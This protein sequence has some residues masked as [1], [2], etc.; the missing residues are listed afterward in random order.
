MKL[1]DRIKEFFYRFDLMDF[2]GKREEFYGQLAESMA[3]KERL[4]TFLVEELQI[5]SAPKTR[6]RSRAL[7]LGLMLKK[8]SSGKEFRLSQILGEVMPSGDRLMLTAL[9]TAKDKVA[10][11]HA[12]REGIAQQREAKAVIFKAI[13]PPLILLPGVGGFSWVMATRSLPVIVDIAPPQ[14]WTN[15]NMAVRLFSEF[16]ASNGLLTVAIVGAAV[17]ALGYAMPRWKGN[18]RGRFEQCS[19]Q[20][21]MLLFPVCPVLLPLSIYRDFQVANLMIS[22][23]VLL[24]SGSTLTDALVTLR[25]NSTPWMRWHLN[26]IL[27]HLQVAPIDYIPAFAKGLMSPKLLARLATTIRNRPQFDQVLVEMGTRGNADIRNEIARTSKGLNLLM[28]LGCAFLVMFL[29]L[30]QLSISQSMT[31]ALNPLNAMKSK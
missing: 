27:L 20:K 5:S 24:R 14:V 30:G 16:V 29:Y 9:D 26:R 13:L 28:M 31:E 7:A 1:F 25:D 22:L 15:F 6:D 10:V 11:L 4:R 12:L 2:Q 19:V 18:L 21:G 17:T 23:A 3:N 8:L